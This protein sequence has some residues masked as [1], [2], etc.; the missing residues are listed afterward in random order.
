MR[1]R[2]AQVEISSGLENQFAAYHG[3]CVNERMSEMTDKF[4]LDHSKEAGSLHHMSD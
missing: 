4:M 2:K 3:V 1:I